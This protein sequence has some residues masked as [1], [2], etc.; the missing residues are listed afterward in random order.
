MSNPSQYESN[1]LIQRTNDDYAA[2]CKTYYFSESLDERG[3]RDINGLWAWQEQERR[4]AA[5]KESYAD[6]LVVAKQC[7]DHD[8]YVIRP[9][10]LPLRIREPLEAAIKKA[11]GV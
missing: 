11:G 1:N 7:L 10:F 2:W 3:H 6:L 9:E 8:D 5:L 4:I